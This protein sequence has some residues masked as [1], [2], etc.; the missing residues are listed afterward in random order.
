MSPLVQQQQETE[1]ERR[2]PVSGCCGV[3]VGVERRGDHQ[4]HRPL[5][6]SVGEIVSWISERSILLLVLHT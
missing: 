3:G 2:S 6:L 4:T 5:C 1:R